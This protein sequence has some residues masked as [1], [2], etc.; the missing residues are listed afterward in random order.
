M[1]EKINL[2]LAELRRL[3]LVENMVGLNFHTSD[4]VIDL[5]VRKKLKTTT[6][7]FYEWT[8]FQKTFKCIFVYRKVL[9][10]PAFIFYCLLKSILV[11]NYSLQMFSCLFFRK[12]RHDVVFTSFTNSSK[13]ILIC[14]ALGTYKT[15]VLKSPTSH[16]NTDL[17][18]FNQKT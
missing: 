1:A 10:K 12:K 7:F 16:N 6:Y 4:N 14:M 5:W 9:E 2:G 11:K 13:K 17:P 3:L 18:T 8:L 15:M